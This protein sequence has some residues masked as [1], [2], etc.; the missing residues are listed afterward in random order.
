MFK[1]FRHKL[2]LFSQIH[3]GDYEIILLFFFG[4]VRLSFLLNY[5]ILVACKCVRPYPTED[6]KSSFHHWLKQ[7]GGS[8]DQHTKN[9]RILEW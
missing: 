3:L 8:L 7:G 6:E 4:E 1:Y 5:T 2:N 9:F